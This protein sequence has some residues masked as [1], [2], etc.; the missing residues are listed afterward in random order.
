MWKE[1][2]Q[3]ERNRRIW[4]EE[5]EAFVP[6]RVWDVH[7]HPVPEGAIPEDAPF[8]CA[9]HPITQYPLEELQQ[10]FADMLPGRECLALCFGLPI[11]GYDRVWNNHYLAKNCPSFGWK[12]LRLLDPAEDT[13]ETLHAELSQGPYWGIKPYPDY[14][15]HAD[16]NNASIAEMLPPWAMEVINELG[17]LVMLHIPRRERLADPLNQRQLVEWCGRYPKA[18]FILAHIGRAYYVRNIVG[19]LDALAE[20]PNLYYDTAMLNNWEVLEY[21]FRHLPEERLLYGS[22]IPIALAPG[23]SI[24]I[25]D[26]YTYVTP[27]PWVLSIHDPRGKLVFTS[28][29]YEELRAIK[30]AVE[31]LDKPRE[32]TERFFHQNAESLFQGLG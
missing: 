31:R 15:R 21:A 2:T 20:L 16:L 6:Q 30:K 18:R 9:G 27:V 26:Q 23:K 14:T 12:A 24:E 8:S 11:V 10:D 1:T 25:N 29:L 3:Q 32:F 22:D 28:F 7:V 4:E 5:L 17:L 13:P 19:Q